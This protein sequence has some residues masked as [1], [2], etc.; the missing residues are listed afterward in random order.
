MIKTDLCEIAKLNGKFSEH[1]LNI[2]GDDGLICHGGNQ[3]WWQDRTPAGSERNRIK[4]MKEDA[5]YRLW[6]LG[7]GVIA[8]SDAELYLALR[9]NGCGLSVPAA[10]DEKARRTGIF[11]KDAYRNYIERMYGTKYTI[12]GNM[13]NLAVGLYPWT[14]EKGLRNF[15]KAGCY[16]HTKVR[17]SK[18]GSF[19]GVM[20]K[21]K[22]LNEIERMLNDDMP[23]VFSYYSFAGD[24]IT[25]YTSLQAAAEMD[26]TG[27]DNVNSHYMTIIGLYGCPGEQSG[28]YRYILKVVSWG[29]I[30]YINY[31]EYAEKLDY[32]SN[33]LSIY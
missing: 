8:M 11:K 5:F 17:W 6:Q 31:D 14:M 18:Y 20:K 15:L 22:I 19:F 33:I 30:Y 16:S 27:A 24:K 10:F 29:K 32:A 7:C 25:L 26:G 9:N 21:Q 3:N 1:Y 4:R 2:E 28:N 12:A 13:L 23:V